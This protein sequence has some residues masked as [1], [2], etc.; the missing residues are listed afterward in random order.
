MLRILQTPAVAQTGRTVERIALAGELRGEW[1]D[2]VGR[3]CRAVLNAGRPLELDLSEV[4]F[5][6]ARGLAL[7]RELASARVPFVTCSLFI[8]VQLETVEKDV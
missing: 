2:E 7:L 5:A 3:T 1:V 6:D 8:A 4:S